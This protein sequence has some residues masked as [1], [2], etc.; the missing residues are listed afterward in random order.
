MI[1]HD[2]I[3]ECVRDPA[4]A[5]EV[6]CWLHALAPNDWTVWELNWMATELRGRRGPG[7]SEQEQALLVRLH[8]CAKGYTQ[9]RQHTVRQWIEFAYARRGSMSGDQSEIVTHWYDRG[10][11]TLRQRQFDNLIAIVT[12]LDE[13][14]K[15]A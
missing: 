13:A 2:R 4:K 5:R 10:L 7:F 15:A 12:S 8:R 11:M 1:D 9:Y 14:E 3:L 6:L